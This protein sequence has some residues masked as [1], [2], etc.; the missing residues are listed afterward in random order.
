MAKSI[1]G[2]SISISWAHYPLLLVWKWYLYDISINHSY[3]GLFMAVLVLFYGY[4]TF[5]WGARRAP[6][7]IPPKRSEG[8]NI[9]IF[10]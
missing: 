9:F 5:V 8:G 4:L 10:N 7:G 3:F 2:F 6:R 1:Y